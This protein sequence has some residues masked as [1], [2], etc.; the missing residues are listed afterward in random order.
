MYRVNLRPAARR[1]LSRIPSRDADRLEQAIVRLAQEPRP[2]GTRKLQGEGNT[3][4]LRVGPYRVLY[5]VFDLDQL[6]QVTHVLRR[7]ESTYR[8]L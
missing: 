4:R 6:V 1:D 3:Y 7:S 5:E 8:N 2:G